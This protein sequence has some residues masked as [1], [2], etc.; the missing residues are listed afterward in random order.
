MQTSLVAPARRPKSDP[1]GIHSV[2]R[3]DYP[4]AVMLEAEGIAARGIVDH[5]GRR[6]RSAGLTID[7]AE[8]RD[9]DDAIWADRLSD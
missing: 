9:L 3:P 7:G 6:V 4:S 8:S 2:I 5:V 1:H